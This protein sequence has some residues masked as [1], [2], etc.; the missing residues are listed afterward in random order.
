MVLFSVAYSLPSLMLSGFVISMSRGVIFFFSRFPQIWGQLCPRHNVVSCIVIRMFKILS[1]SFQSTAT[2][3]VRATLLVIF[4]LVCLVLISFQHLTNVDHKPRFSTINDEW[5]TMDLKQLLNRDPED[6]PA[7]F[8]YRNDKLILRTKKEQKPSEWRSPAGPVPVQSDWILKN[9]T[10]GVSIYKPDGKYKD[11]VLVVLGGNGYDETAELVERGY[12]V[13]R[14]NEPCSDSTKSKKSTK[15]HEQYGYLGYLSDPTAPKHEVVN[16]IH[17]HKYAWHQQYGFKGMEIASHCALKTGRFEPHVKHEAHYRYST[18]K[19]YESEH[20][21]KKPYR[22]MILASNIKMEATAVM[23][24]HYYGSFI[25]NISTTD[26]VMH[27]CCANFAVPRRMIE[28]HSHDDYK[29]VFDVMAT[30]QQPVM[31]LEMSG[32]W[33][34]RIWHLLFGEPQDVN[35]RSERW[36]NCTDNS[37]NPSYFKPVGEQSKSGLLVS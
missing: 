31:E 33:I 14:M 28:L 21:A 8:S 19:Q 6:R 23:F 10:Y 22:P 13:W 27:W 25:R 20:G 37:Y 34:E 29:K 1:F 36:V 7:S 5:T 17:G 18:F 26:R 3:K 35:P 4:L 24:N 16:F 12:T 11:S 2:M 15:C 30:K 32:F 9:S